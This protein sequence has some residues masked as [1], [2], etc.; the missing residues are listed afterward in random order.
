[1]F[2]RKIVYLFMLVGSFTYAQFSCPTITYP[3]DGDTNVPVDTEISWTPV[4]GID[5]YSVSIGTTPMG[6][7]ILNSRSAALVNSLAPVVG[8]PPNT[9]IFV[10]I[11]LY[12]KDGSFITCPPESFFTENI[13]TPPDCTVLNSPANGSDNV[14]PGDNISW[15]YARGATGYRLAIGTTENNFELLPETD[16]GNVLSYSPVENLPTNTEIFIRITPYNE[17]GDA[18]LCTLQRF[19]TGD[20]NIDC[21]QFKPELDI[22]P[23]VGICRGEEQVTVSTKVIADGFRWFQ[24]HSNASETLISESLMVTISEPGVYRFEAYN[25]I[26]LFGETTE[27]LSTTNFL[28]NDSDV[29]VVDKI[30]STRDAMGVR[31]EILVS[32][33]G[34]YEYALDTIDGPYQD[35]NVFSSV[36][37]DDIWIYVRDKNGCGITEYLFVQ[38]ISEADF[39]KFFTP[40]GD[41]INDYWKFSPISETSSSLEIVFI[42]DQYGNLVSQL[43]PGSQGWDGTFNGRPLLSSTF[44]YQAI[45]KSGKQIRGFFALKR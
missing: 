5:G 36:P 22:P 44:W 17:N 31:L 1:M 10:T 23:N 18:G 16:V 21:E 3:F 11:S 45:S 42:F 29:A 19:I 27:C 32:G 25:N 24:I 4:P 14:R 40:N 41:G 7:E 37:S 6:T 9:E 39:P 26:S 15:N 43:A 12:L 35:S 30:H 38:T 2:R 34:N 13:T 8:L 28:V 33:P 20:S